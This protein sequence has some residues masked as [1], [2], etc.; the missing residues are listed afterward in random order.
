MASSKT[1]SYLRALH[2]MQTHRFEGRDMEKK[3]WIIK[4]HVIASCAAK[5][6]LKNPLAARPDTT[7][8]TSD[9]ATSL[10]PPHLPL[11]T[12]SCS[13]PLPPSFTHAKL[14]SRPHDSFPVIIFAPVSI[15]NHF[16]PGGRRQ[17]E[18]GGEGRP[19]AYLCVFWACREQ[20][21]TRRRATRPGAS[22]RRPPRTLAAR[23]DV[24]PATY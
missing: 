19:T 20:V 9:P 10:L 11:A 6:G 7:S 12:S 5:G 18:V 22:P 14:S 3:L 2:I 1:N 8:R 24:L 4:K 13:P 23:G 15:P 16:G 17:G 21:M